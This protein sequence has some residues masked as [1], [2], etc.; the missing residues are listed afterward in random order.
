MLLVQI[1]SY[2]SIKLND[3]AVAIHAGVR[4]ARL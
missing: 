4:V 3:F 1:G 2:T